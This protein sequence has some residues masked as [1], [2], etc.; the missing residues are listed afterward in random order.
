MTGW[1][2]ALATNYLRGIDTGGWMP[3]VVAASDALA[4]ILMIAGLHQIAGQHKKYKTARTV[5]VF[6]LISA[7]G[8]LAVLI[9]AS[10]GIVLWM[11]IAAT[12]LTMA[13]AILFLILTGLFMT[14]TADLVQQGG[15]EPA[16]RKLGYRWTLFLTFGVLYVVMQA[17]AVLLVNQG[18]A[19]LTYVVLAVG[20]PVLI[21][22]LL[23]VTQVYR[24]NPLQEL[25]T[26]D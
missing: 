11:A 25:Q 2:L 14:G 12:V 1:I 26:T 4:M 8:L 15:D 5:A 23:I 24:S 17:I 10:R 9:F 19:A 7:L 16:A 20:V 22:G 21:A 6:A 13:T 3:L 18:L